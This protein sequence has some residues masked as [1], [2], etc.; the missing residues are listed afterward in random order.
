MNTL[1][2]A[3]ERVG[4][5]L[6]LAARL[7]FATLLFSSP[8]ML[9]WLD[10]LRRIEPVYSGYTDF[11]IYPSDLWLGLT[12]LFGLTAPLVSGAKFKCG[13]WYLTLP[14]AALVVLSFVSA[15]GRVDPALSLYHSVRFVALFGLYLVLV[16]TPLKPAWV[17]VPLALAILV[18]S[19]VGIAQ[20]I[21]QSSIGL[22]SWGEL[23]LDPAQ[24]GVSI[25]RHD[26]S[27]ILRAYGLTDHPNLLGG[28]LAFALIFVLGYDL[29]STPAKHDRVRY[30]FLVPLAMGTVALVYTFSRSAQLAFGVGALFIVLTSVRLPARRRRTLIDLGV[31][32]AV[33]LVA[34]SVPIVTNQ[35]LIA[36]RVGQGN[37]FNENSGEVRSLVERDELIES[38]NRIFYQ[39][40][41]LG[42]GNGALT[43]GMYYL[44]RE[45][46]KDT[47][48][49]QPA[50]L[51][52]LVVAA[53]LGIFGGF[54]WL[55]LMAAPLVVM[56]RRRSQIVSSR[57]MAT[58]A[59]A[60]LVLLIVSFFDYYPW[61]WQSGRLWQWS[62][63]GLFAAVFSIRGVNE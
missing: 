13:P 11:F 54:F 55:W 53:E 46:P 12:L 41:L 42:V 10:V 2:P 61:F 8:W 18:Q 50:H 6:G 3:R 25:L 45:F 30:L 43:L 22:Q 20:F 16:N 1:S 48:Y 27:R 15:P 37:A 49:Y 33:L 31:A 58:V 51:V 28:F 23:V 59:A 63:W 24:T 38:A 60:L 62:V 21:G 40:P 14:L 32:A 29:D 39:R 52:P 36:Q 35:R 57:W 9:Q 47:Y 44:D 56:W 17:A 4:S 34:T 7:A 19:S 5:F 26:N